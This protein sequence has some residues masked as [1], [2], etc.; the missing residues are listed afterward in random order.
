M[1][2]GIVAA[3]VSS[4]G[5]MLFR[6][7]AAAPPAMGRGAL[8]PLPVCGLGRSGGTLFLEALSRHPEIVVCPRW[9]HEQR[10]AAFLAV[11]RGRLRLRDE[12]ARNGA[13]DPPP[14]EYKNGRSPFSSREADLERD[15][16]EAA[17]ARVDAAMRDG[18]T[19]FYA[20]LAARLAKPAPRRFAEKVEPCQLRDYVETFTGARVIALVRD[21]RDA[22]V[23]TVD[24]FERR[25]GDASERRTG[26]RPRCEALRELL[27]SRWTRVW[28]EYPAALEW[29][30]RAGFE[31]HVV[32][33]EEL[34]RQPER[35]LEA[36]ARFAGLTAPD[37]VAL[38]AAAVREPPL[39]AQHL[40]SESVESS[41]G[42]WRR[43]LDGRAQAELGAAVREVVA[44]FGYA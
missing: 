25:D 24:W 27:A 39:R 9:P 14:C 26:P 18:I 37:G 5:S 32:R 16:A 44:A 13:P 36:I 28:K 30:R 41:I 43:D 6:R 21:P 40:T 7:K 34:V 15:Y 42:R 19:E 10:P 2:R 12:A 35:T 22:L 1:K 20:R 33:Y 3:G 8:L 17:L 4:A 23:S 38:A 31:P 11:A 29:A